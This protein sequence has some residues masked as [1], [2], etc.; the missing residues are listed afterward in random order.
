LFVELLIVVV[1]IVINGLLAMSELAV[2]SARP[3]R[4][5]TMADQGNAAAL[6]AIELAEDPGKFL[7]SVQIGITLVGILSGAFSGATLGLR[8]TAWLGTVGVPGNIADILGVGVVVVGI[9]YISLILG[10]LVPKQIALRDAESVAARVAPAMKLIAAIGSP[11]VWVLDISGR[12]VLAL[13]GQSGES[14]ETMTE[15]EV[16]SIIAEATTAGVI[17]SDEHS[18]ISGVMRLADRSARGLM[19]PRL[20][21]DVLD[22]SDESEE[23]RR[24]I[25]DTSRSRL[26]VQD[27]DGDSIIGVVAIKDIIGVF[28]NGLPLELRKFVQPVP[29]VMDHADAL[30]VVRAIRNSTVHMALVVDEYG[31]FEGIVTSAD[32]LEVITGV[33]QEETGDDPAVVKR[34]DGSWLVAGWM[35][36]DEFSDK[37]KIAIPRDAKFETVAGYVLSIINRLPAVGETFE[38]DGY[39]IEVVD[40]DGRR[41]DKILMTK[42]PD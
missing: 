23:I 36:A 27:G 41:I 5:R 24:T 30:D 13:L 25:L 4:L 1:L 15:E 11:V 28:A 16:K 31:H 17:E 8:L 9:T 14:D 22:L 6:T 20:D 29:V 12:A 35:P 40:L 34:E 33:F 42:L 37:L 18:M 3:A 32:I 21:V 26:L 39:K 10:E 19:T 7:S 2:V 38:H